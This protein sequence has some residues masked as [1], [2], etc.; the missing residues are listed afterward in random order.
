[1]AG[2]ALYASLFEPDIAELNL[3]D[4]PTTH[5]DGPFLLNVSRFFDLPQAVTLAAEDSRIVLHGADAAN[6][7]Y[8]LQTAKALGW[9]SDVVTIVE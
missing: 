8:P 7:A 1:M 5:R 3:Y 9:D 6:W 4:L 2:V